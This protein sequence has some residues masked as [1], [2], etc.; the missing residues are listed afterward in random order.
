MDAHVNFEGYHPSSEGETFSATLERG[1]PVPFARRQNLQLVVVVLYSIV[2][3][4]DNPRQ[5]IT[6]VKQYEYA[7]ENET[8][9]EILA[10]HWHP[11]SRNTPPWP[12]L[13]IGSA[14]LHANYKDL[15]K[16]HVRTERIALEDV[17][18]FAINELKVPP[19]KRREHDWRDVLAQERETFERSLTRPTSGIE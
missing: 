16:A 9:Q 2:P 19:T 17:L 7:I 6:S 11:N 12:H 15:H 13:H 5:W 3:A 10:Y 18:W 14:V 1:D 4:S 8:G